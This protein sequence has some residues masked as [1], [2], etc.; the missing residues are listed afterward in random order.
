MDEVVQVGRAAVEPA[1]EV[2]GLALAGPAVAAPGDAAPVA[3]DQGFELGAGGCPAGPADVERLDPRWT[4]WSTRAASTG[5][6]SWVVLSVGAAAAGSSK[7]A[8]VQRQALEPLMPGS[9]AVTE[10]ADRGR[11]PEANGRC[12]KRHASAIARQ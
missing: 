1:P 4:P 7:P 6:A 9:G 2:V 10:A 11:R 12:C 5:A 3:H 8:A